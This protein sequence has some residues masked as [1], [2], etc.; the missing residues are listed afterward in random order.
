MSQLRIYQSLVPPRSPEPSRRFVH[1]RGVGHG[2]ERCPL[3][4]EEGAA[5]G[6]H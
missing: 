6:K 5:L 1:E 3:G 2:V 4:D